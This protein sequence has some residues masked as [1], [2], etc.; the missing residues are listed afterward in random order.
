LTLI[1]E[2]ITVNRLFLKQI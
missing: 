2:Y 1:V